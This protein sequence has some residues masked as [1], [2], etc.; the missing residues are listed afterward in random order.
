MVVFLAKVNRGL[1]RI[2]DRGGSRDRAWSGNCQFV[3]LDNTCPH[4]LDTSTYPRENPANF[5][6][7]CSLAE[8]VASGIDRFN[9]G[10][11]RP[12]GKM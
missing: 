4:G 10:D 5:E 6:N 2:G 3:R 9:F 7:S 11:C 12:L 8:S 1:P